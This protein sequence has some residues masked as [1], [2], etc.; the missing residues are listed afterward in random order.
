[1]LSAFVPYCGHS[2]V[3][4]ALV[5]N[6]DPVLISLLFAVGASY[7]FGSRGARAPETRE[8]CYF[9]LGLF[10]TAAALLSPLCNLSVALFSARVAQHVILTLIAAPLI[11][12]GRPEAA[13]AALLP[14]VAA[15]R[16]REGHIGVVVGAAAFVLAMWTW[17]MPGPYDDTFKSN[18]VYW[19]MHVTTFGSALAMWH[20]LLQ[21]SQSLGTAAAAIAT[22]IQMSLL[23]AVLTL[24]PRP[25]FMVHFSTTWP[26]GL[27]PLADQQLGGVIMWILAGTLVTAYGLTAF[28]CW[29]NPNEHADTAVQR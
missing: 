14:R 23:G 19:L 5:W 17:H 15:R 28:A 25:L 4:G 9:G 21:R 1:M 13:V 10:I 12:L 20:F 24:A 7:V 3:P 26:W 22:G 27:S 16:R 2:P 6:S 29:L 11:V 18:L 8:R